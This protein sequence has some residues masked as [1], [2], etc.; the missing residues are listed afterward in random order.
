[1][2]IYLRFSFYFFTN[3]FLQFPQTVFC[4][5]T[6]HT[7]SS[8]SKIIFSHENKIPREIIHS[9]SKPSDFVI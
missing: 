6:T 4:K 7:K 1:M 2:E 9:G 8:T 3:G 5:K